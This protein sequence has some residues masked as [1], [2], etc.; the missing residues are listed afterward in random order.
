[1]EDKHKIDVEH[2]EAPAQHND[3]PVREDEAAH[4]LTD[5]VRDGFV[6]FTP[7]LLL[8]H[9]LFDRD[10]IVEFNRTHETE[11]EAERPF[12]VDC[13]FPFFQN[14][15]FGM[16]GGQLVNWDHRLYGICGRNWEELRS[17]LGAL[18]W[19]D[20]HRYNYA[21]VGS[22]ALQ[23]ID[24]TLLHDHGNALTELPFIEITVFCVS[25][26][27]G[28]VW[29]SPATDPPRTRPFPRVEPPRKRLQQEAEAVL[30]PPPA[31]EKAHQPPA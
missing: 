13:Q 22:H 21:R 24:P 6:F 11:D 7:A 25:T 4:T 12:F 28:F 1:M 27:R 2:R 14:L 23:I 3:S 26:Y 16:V 5:M 30:G 15:G 19:Y 10:P 8:T 31:P 17:F 29:M 18:A 9:G 20:P